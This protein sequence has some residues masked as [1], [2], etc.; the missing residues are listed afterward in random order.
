MKQFQYINK[1]AMSKILKKHDKRT[2]LTY[3]FFI[4]RTN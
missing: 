2:Y 3:V 4:I 1:T